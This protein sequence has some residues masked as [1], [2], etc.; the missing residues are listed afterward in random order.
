[1]QPWAASE[2]CSLTV[3]SPNFKP[4]WDFAVGWNEA[5]LSQLLFPA[6]GW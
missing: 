2:V 6:D 5:L 4:Q 1:M 3:L